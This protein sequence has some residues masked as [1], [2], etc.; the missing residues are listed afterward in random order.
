MT[1][2]Q[3]A[4]RVIYTG[5]FLDEPS[6]LRLFHRWGGMGYPLFTKLHGDHVT[7]QFRPESLDGFEVGK[8]VEMLVGAPRC[9]EPGVGCFEVEIPDH[10]RRLM[11]PG[12][13]PHI[14]VCT[15]EGV[16]PFHSNRLIRAY[17]DGVTD[18]SAFPSPY[19]THVINPEF[20]TADGGDLILTGTTDVFTGT[21]RKGNDQ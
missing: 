11:A 20:P 10:L 17:R 13:H 3:P 8:V 7:I 15:H 1:R 18:A 4:A 2:P 5:I 6:R 9:G 21:H 14:T 16:L 12:D 19:L